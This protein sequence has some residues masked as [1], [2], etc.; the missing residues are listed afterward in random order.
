MTVETAQQQRERQARR[1]LFDAVAAAYDEVRHRYSPTI[2]DTISTTAA[3]GSDAQ[4]LEIGCGTG[5]LTEQLCGRGLRLT[6]IDIGVTMIDVARQRLADPRLR[7]EVTS[8][9]DLAAENDSFDLVVSADAFHWVDPA[10]RFTKAARLLRRGG[11]LALLAGGPCYPEPLGSAVRELWM[12][13]NRSN[14]PWSDTPEWWN[15]LRG[16]SLFGAVDEIHHEEVQS[17][18]P[19]AIVRLECTRATFLGFDEVDQ[20]AFTAD[21]RKLVGAYERIEVRYK[22]HVA[23]APLLVHS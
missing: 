11:W 5:Q 10:L 16:S 13:Y 15:G 21:L 6:A 18:S 1:A 4:V 14:G 3:L 2:V 22:T 12:K 7:F 17:R 20:M 9:E 8:F 23:M 19:E